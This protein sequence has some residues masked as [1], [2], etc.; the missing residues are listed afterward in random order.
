MERMGEPVV[1]LPATRDTILA[2][3][4]VA[5]IVEAETGTQIVAT[6]DGIVWNAATT[7]ET[8]VIDGEVG[9]E[10]GSKVMEKIGDT[11]MVANM[12]A[13]AGTVTIVVAGTV[14]IVAT[15]IAMTVAPQTSTVVTDSPTA[16]GIV[17]KG[18]PTIAHSLATGWRTWT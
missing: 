3:A 4:T 8:V 15:E 16:G 17:E 6:K 5:R 13:V 14:T 10:I 11:T 12:T 7:A 2:V 1:I 18:S 9:I